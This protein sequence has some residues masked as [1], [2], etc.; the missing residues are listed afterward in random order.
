MTFISSLINAFKTLVLAVLALALAF[1]WVH[2]NNDQNA[3]VLGV[4]AAGFV[5]ISSVA[6][7]FVRKKV[8]PL[9]RPRDADGAALKAVKA[10]R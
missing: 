2:W 4:V 6:T 10:T 1:D 8:T 7:V 5:I 9:A 3:A